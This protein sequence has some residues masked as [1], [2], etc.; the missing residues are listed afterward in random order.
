MKTRQ[1]VVDMAFRRLGIKAEDESLTAD[2][3]AY[4]G[5]VLEGLFAEMSLHAPMTWW[6]DQIED[7]VAVP[8][9]ALLAAEIGPSYG[10]DGGPRSRAYARVMAVIMPDNRASAD[11][12]TGEAAYF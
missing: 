9:A 1:D 8:L 7:A 2:Q 4:A 5:D 12:P 6:P 3:S 11:R 10:V